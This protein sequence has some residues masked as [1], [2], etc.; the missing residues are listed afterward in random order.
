MTTDPHLT[1]LEKTAIIRMKKKYE[2]YKREV[3]AVNRD[4]PLEQRQYLKTLT[5]CIDIDLLGNFT[6]DRI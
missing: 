1:E 2:E 4:K 5:E 3:E 6:K